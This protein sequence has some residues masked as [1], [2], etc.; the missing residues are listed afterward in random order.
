M[1]TID[2]GTILSILGFAGYVVA[3]IFAFRGQWDTASKTKQSEERQ[4][5]DDL[6]K[7]LQQT[8]DQQAKDLEKMRDDMKEHTRV[9]DLEVKD[10]RDKVK[11]LEGRNGVLEDLFRGRDPA[12]QTFLRDAPKLIEIAHANNALAKE[13]SDALTH[14]T[15]TIASF[16]DTLQP[17][18]LK[19]EVKKNL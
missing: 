7:R 5:S 11:H 12:M 10:L 1:T 18:L 17:L 13:N 6:I 19:L 15:T 2:I 14:L 9:R 8:V 16:V 4:L 3:G